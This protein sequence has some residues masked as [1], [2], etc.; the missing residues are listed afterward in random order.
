M[1]DKKSNIFNLNGLTPQRL[2]EMDSLI[3]EK[4]FNRLSLED[5]LSLV[6]A[7]SWKDRVDMVL[8][9]RNP[10]ELIH[11]MPEEELYWTVKMYGERDSLQLLS[12]TSHDQL[13]YIYDIE[14]W[15]K[16]L[17]DKKNLE[18]WLGILCRLSEE[19][20][21]DWFLNFDQEFIIASLKKLLQVFKVEADNDLSEEYLNLPYYTMDGVYF[22]NFL[23]PDS[24]V[25]LK[26]MLNV[27]YENDSNWFY[28]LMEGIIWDS[29][30]E[31]EET[32]FRFKQSRL[33]EKGFPSVDE[34]M[35]VYQLI[36]D[37]EIEGLKKKVQ[38][39]EPNYSSKEGRDL[40]PY[41]F[42]ECRDTFIF[43]VMAEQQTSETL[44]NISK[45][46]ISI[47]NR[48]I[49][50][51]GLVP[52]DLGDIK[53][54]LFKTA[55][56]VNIG[57][58]YFSGT[59]TEYAKSVLESIHPFDLFR[60]GHTKIWG[61]KKRL[62]TICAENSDLSFEFLSS[63]I[64]TPWSETIKGL[65]S[66]RPKFYEGLIDEKS[67]LVRDFKSTGE[68]VAVSEVLDIVQVVLKLFRSVLPGAAEA[69]NDVKEDFTGYNIS[70]ISL[71]NTLAALKMLKISRKEVFLT[72]EELETFILSVVKKS[73]ANI[74]NSGIMEW[75]EGMSVFTESHRK[76]LQN[77]VRKSLLDLKQEFSRVENIGEM[78]SKYIQKIVIK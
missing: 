9:D 55:G 37:A 28:M 56:C 2:K 20:V 71:F 16:D 53:I 33:S 68:V 47:A 17:I 57:L 44:Q 48:I 50:A 51:D 59:D 60:A 65:N 78:D 35:A 8:M 75:L 18:K 23:T 54:A 29:P 69:M 61:L 70:A 38:E 46:I 45:N 7:A 6:M 1:S 5:K 73:K 72:L 13:Q 40:I 49:V 43:Q 26:P 19:K 25:I 36:S 27:L 76:A 32:A 74:L 3:A 21:V 4:M 64:D 66:R 15:N 58:E 12:M 34:A 62:E 11:A 24:E 42:H 31:D 77:F 10:V 30:H 63:F 39:K 67:L 14:L 22:L 52:K 41:F